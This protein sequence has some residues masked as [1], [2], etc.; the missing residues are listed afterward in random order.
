MELD[1]KL[2]NSQVKNVVNPIQHDKSMLNAPPP[3]I[4][5]DKSEIDEGPTIKH[6][7]SVLNHGNESNIEDVSVSPN[8]NSISNNLIVGEKKTPNLENEKTKNNEIEV[9]QNIALLEGKR[10]FGASFM[11]F[12]G[13]DSTFIQLQKKI[14]LLN[15]AKTPADRNKIKKEV[16]SLG[17][18]WL[19]KHGDVK[20]ENDQKK[21][22]SIQKIVDGLKTEESPEKKGTGSKEME[23]VS[24][25]DKSTLGEKVISAITGNESEFLKIET[26]FAS[27]LIL[28]QGKI[29]SLEFLFNV[30]K[31]AKDLNSKVESY[32][33]KIEKSTS[34]S[35]IQKL[36]V[37]NKIKTNLGSVSFDYNINKNIFVSAIDIDL[38]K[39]LE[40]QIVVK[41]AQIFVNLNGNKP[42]SGKVNDLQLSKTE[43]SFK[44]A[45]IEYDQSINFTEGLAVAV[46]KPKIEVLKLEGGYD[47]IAS[48]GLEVA[49][50][51][52]VNITA[53]AK[54]VANYNTVTE[55]WGVEISDCKISGDIDKVVTFEINGVNYK[56]GGLTAL[57]AAASLKYGDKLIEG[58]INDVTLSKEGFN[59]RSASLTHKGDIGIGNAV[60]VANASAE[61]KGKKDNYDKKFSGGLTL[62]FGEHSEKSIT[63]SGDVAV[64]KVES[65]WNTIVSNG[66]LDVKILDGLVSLNAKGINYAEGKLTITASQ[67]EL[68]TGLDVLPKI[69][70]EGKEIS[71]SDKEGFDWAEL[72]L[73]NLGDFSPFENFKFLAPKVIWK[74]KKDKYQLF[75]EN[76]TI[77]ANTFNGNLAAVGTASMILDYVE[78]KPLEFKFTE[79]SLAIKATTPISM[80]KDFL[81]GGIWPYEPSFSVP[82]VSG[83]HAGIGLKFDGGFGISVAGKMDYNASTGFDLSAESTVTGKSLK[84]AISV[85]VGLGI[86]NVA[87]LNAYVSAGAEATAEGSI[88]IK[89]TATKKA[90][91]KGFDF[92]KITGNY[93]LK[94]QASAFVDA[95]LNAKLLGFN[96]N[97]VAFNFGKWTI[98]EGTIAGEL[99]FGKENGTKS[100]NN[101][102]TGFFEGKEKI[103][104]LFPSI[105]NDNIVT[106]MSENSQKD[107]KSEE[108][109]KPKKTAIAYIQM[110]N[111]KEI[112]SQY[113]P[114]EDINI[115][116]DDLS[117][118]MKKL[119]LRK[120]YQQKSR[121]KTITESQREN[122]KLRLKQYKLVEEEILKI[123]ENIEKKPAKGSDMTDFISDYSKHLFELEI[124]LKTADFDEK[125]EKV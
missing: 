47:V 61:I 91:G 14:D 8:S 10:S 49:V 36:G 107:P 30:V 71:F 52:S 17:Q 54:V 69:T 41:E 57:S 117:D 124:L 42:I 103:N 96:Y 19:E 60:S 75:I 74:G 80:P 90:D 100:E 99:G 87:E 95:G 119:T 123:K 121:L 98:G 111:S 83:V 67:L 63:A 25:S 112:N 55:K 27:H 35:D 68:T 89:S 11:S 32:S 125:I 76:G 45:T 85:Y 86:P 37:L 116:L 2:D 50:D 110:F 23:M 78:K 114:A 66:S 104:S 16:L 1:P 51:E 43:A 72:S 115:K 7:D 12:F 33:T 120:E 97:I 18:I 118:D 62:D 26:Q 109:Y 122:I 53:V 59:W 46:V 29:K 21:R 13:K 34:N 88:G 84:F 5:K 64:T 58:N 94:A 77:E 79:A 65:G 70:A 9:T 106:N 56:D 44:S 6:N 82:I 102:S 31:S 3:S 39:A 28:A 113:F 93:K 38:S 101:T 81:P 20:N 73:D 92:S 24:M 108:L 4:V 22:D 105:N 15:T 48:G 40:E